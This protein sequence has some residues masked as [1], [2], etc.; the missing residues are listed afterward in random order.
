MKQEWFFKFFPFFPM[1]RMM[2]AIFF[3][4]TL[5]HPLFNTITLAYFICKHSPKRPRDF[6]KTFRGDVIAY[7]FT[8]PGI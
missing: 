5:N 2:K 3:P 4:N 6:C 1:G 8:T 7:N